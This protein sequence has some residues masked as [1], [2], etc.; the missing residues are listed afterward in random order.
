MPLKHLRVCDHC[1]TIRYASCSTVCQ[2][3]PEQDP[4]SW[5]AN[6]QD[7]AGTLPKETP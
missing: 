4:D 5:R 3:P 2:A 6:L 7:G 1:H